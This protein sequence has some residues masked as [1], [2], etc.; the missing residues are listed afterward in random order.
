MAVFVAGSLLL[1]VALAW[2]FRRLNRAYELL[3]ER[4]EHLV[5]ANRE[6]ALAAKTSAVGAVTSH[7]IHGLRNPLA[8]LQNF[9]SGLGA[10]GPSDADGDVQEAI[11]STRRMQNMIS[12]ILTVLRE[13]E[14]AGQYEVTLTDLVAIIS[15]KVQPFCRQN[16]VELLAKVKTA[17][18][19]SNRTANLTGLILANLIQNAI[20]ATPKDGTVTLSFTR[21]ADSVACEVGDEGPGFPA[22]RK[23]FEPC[24]STKEGRSGI[25]LAISKQLA[26]HL[27][28]G[29]ELR[30]STPQ[31]CVFALVLPRTLWA[32][33][34][35]TVTMT[36]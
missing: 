17:A 3:A 4:T 27:G 10:T 25:G 22:D 28:A 2:F 9:V 1:A 7:L 14:G 20:E 31:G 5:Q 12:E 19:L 8:G 23:L 34:S 29:L 36:A 15:T 35:R 32:E 30:R 24:H 13:E 6:L 26:N 33:S 21:E 11:A 16:G 18:V